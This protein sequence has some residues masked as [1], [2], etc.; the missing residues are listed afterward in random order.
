MGSHACD[1][2][3]GFESMISDFGDTLS[4]LASSFAAAAFPQPLTRM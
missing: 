3:A 2:M 1:E 4:R